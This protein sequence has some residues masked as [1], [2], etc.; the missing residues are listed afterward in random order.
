MGRHLV[1]LTFDFDTVTGWMAR[2]QT[3]PTLISRGEF[4]LVGAARLRVLLARYEIRSTW[5]IPGLTIDTFPDACRAIAHDGHEIA[6]HGYEHVAPAGLSREEEATQLERGNEAIRGIAG[7]HARGYRSPAWDLSAHTV[8]LLLERGFVYDSSMMGHD[9]LPYHARTGDVVEPGKPIQFGETTSLVE[10]P[11]SWSVDDYP[12][13]EYMRGA[14]LRTTG[15]VLENWLDDYIYMTE[16]QDWG[17]LTYTCHPF[18]IGRGHR[19]KMLE[20]L[21]VELK[22]RG[23]V[24][25]TAE[26]AVAEFSE[27]VS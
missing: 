8:D 12:H 20:R 22:E 27:R 15:G 21:I 18:V 24:F 11:I 17:V 2:G 5:Y 16:I 1:C 14:G 19:M 7:Q 23:A 26:E 6:H 3:S 13:F 9:Y 4:G 25:V 10:L